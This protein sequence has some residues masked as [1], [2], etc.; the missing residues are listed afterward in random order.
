MKP[1]TELVLLLVSCAL[2]VPGRARA[3]DPAPPP[4]MVPGSALKIPGELFPSDCVS[5]SST[6][7]QLPVSSRSHGVVVRLVKR[8]DTTVSRNLGLTT[9]L[10]PTTNIAAQ[11]GSID[12]TESGIA[13]TNPNNRSLVAERHRERPFLVG[14]PRSLCPSR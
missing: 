3:Q 7:D 5:G 11:A 12:E 2:L 8:I 6:R 9:G 13:F 1:F 4:V 14:P 10:L